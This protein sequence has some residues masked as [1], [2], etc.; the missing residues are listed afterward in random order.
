MN[1][2]KTFLKYLKNKL[3]AMGFLHHTPKL[4]LSYQDKND[5]RQYGLIHFTFSV[6]MNSIL[7]N[8]VLPGKEYLYRKEKNLC[9]LY[10][11]YPKDYEKNLSIVKSK[12][13]RSAVDCYIV[14]KDFSEEQFDNMRIR[15]ESDNA[16][17]LIGILKTRNM[18]G[19]MIEAK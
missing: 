11:N 8:G 13:K 7:E 5:I 1:R 2:E 14:I 19:M 12:G 16:V 6:N 9:W 3:I 10:I 4:L 18:K 17:V 15:K